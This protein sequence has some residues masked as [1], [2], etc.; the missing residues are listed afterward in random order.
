VG[1]GF[2]G[3]AAARALRKARARVCLID[4][5]NHHLFQ[6]LLYQVATGVL[7]PEHIAAPLRQLLGKQAN[8][9]VLKETV[10]GVDVEKKLCVVEGVMEGAPVSLPYEYLVLATGVQ[11]SYFG[12]NE[13]IPFAPGLKL[14]L[15]PTT[16]E[17]DPGR[18]RN[19]ERTLIPRLIPNW[20]TFNVVGAGPTGVE[21]AEPR[22]IGAANP[23][24]EFGG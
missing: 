5:T 19:C 16:F 1:G 9:L 21:L 14:L 8:T 15:T 10:I 7:S 12:N 3:L 11:T 24:S 17:H 13:Y 6:P 18:L 20:I 2:G 23:A 22:G 4:K